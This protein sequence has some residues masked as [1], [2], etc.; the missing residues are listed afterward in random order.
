M[1]MIEMIANELLPQKKRTI[2]RED[3]K[4]FEENELCTANIEICKIHK[5][6]KY[7]GIPDETL[8]AMIGKYPEVLYVMYNIF[9]HCRTFL[10]T[11]KKQLLVL[12]PTDPLEAFSYKF[13]Y[14]AVVHFCGKFILGRLMS[15]TKNSSNPIFLP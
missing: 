11:W 5:V 4:N 1:N 8:K 15:L 9:W 13:L 7:D 12:I 3:N 10:D 2:W 14:I 6:I